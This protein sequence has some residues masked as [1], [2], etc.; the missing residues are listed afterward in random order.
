M[1]RSKVEKAYE[2][3]E[4]YMH[5]RVHEGVL[6]GEMME[7]DKEVNSKVNLDTVPA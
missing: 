4:E 7:A 3:V 6:D 1:R 5:V 2:E